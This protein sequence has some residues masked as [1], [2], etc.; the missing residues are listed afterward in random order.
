[1]FNEEYRGRLLRQLN[2]K[3]APTFLLEARRFE[4]AL[5]LPPSFCG[6]SSVLGPDKETQTKKVSGTT[7]DTEV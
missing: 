2:I 3:P 6:S 1:M 5:P 4:A 7:K